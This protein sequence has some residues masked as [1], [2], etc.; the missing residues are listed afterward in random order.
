MLNSSKLWIFGDSF[1]YQ[2]PQDGPTVKLWPRLVAEQLSAIMRRPF[3]LIN[4]SLLGSGQEYTWYKLRDNIAEIGSGDYVVITLTHAGRKWFFKDLP[5]LRSA[6]VIDFDDVVG[7]ERARAAELYIK[8]IQRPEQDFMDMDQRFA[9]LDWQVKQRS[10]R[11][12]VILNCFVQDFLEPWPYDGI[13]MSHG[14][15]FK[16]VQQRE[17]LHE[18]PL[19][20]WQGH[21]LRYMHLTLR[22]HQVLADK[23]TR[24]LWRG[25]DLDLR[26][27]FHEKIIDLN[28]WDREDILAELN[29]R[30]VED[31]RRFLEQPRDTNSW[32]HRTGIDKLFKK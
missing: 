25:L 23:L 6:F 27:G 11:K 7:E 26:E 1:S 21:D 22:N 16:D 24:S 29:P 10:L 31:Y 20:H 8:H 5:H 19:D 4:H 9:W 18:A 14:N 17:W 32:V 3:T 28:D 13:T 15:L 2:D 12:P 30:V